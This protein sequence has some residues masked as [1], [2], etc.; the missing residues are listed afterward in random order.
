MTREQAKEKA[1]KLWGQSAFAV[2]S[3]RESGFPIYLVGEENGPLRQR[4]GEGYTWD[5]AFQKAKY[6]LN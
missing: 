6:R 3:L 4:Y 5:Q 1:R 2:V